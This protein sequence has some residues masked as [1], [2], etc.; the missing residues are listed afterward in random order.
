[1]SIC[2]KLLGT[3]AAD[4]DWSRFGE[5]GIRGSTS[6]LLN[7]HT[8]IDCGATG[9]GNLHRF[10]VPFS[11]VDTLLITHSHS[12][13][14]Q[15]AQITELAAG[16]SKPLEVYASPEALELLPQDGSI[17]PHPLAAG[18]KFQ[19]GELGVTALPANH[20]TNIAGEEAFHFAFESAA[21]NLLY[22]LDGAGM[23][24]RAIQLIDHLRFE[25]IIFDC[26]MADS[27]DYRIFE[28]TDIEMVIHL[29]KTLRTLKIVD[30]S[31]RIVLNHLARTLWPPTEA[32]R[33]QKIAGTNFELAFDGME[34]Q[35]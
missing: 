8:L 33:R 22:A 34:L 3:G 7:G 5:E 19:L 26:T 18:M 23:L 1:M 2:L 25:L 21:G 32:E 17:A 27:G 16:R 11:A 28:H 6:S 24:K 14:F 30:G 35:F 9:L 29:M 20:L 31:T 13:H 12:D 4:Y 10:Q 15:P